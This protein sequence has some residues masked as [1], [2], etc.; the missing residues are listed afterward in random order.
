MGTVSNRGTKDRPLWYCRYV[1]ADGKRK[2]RPTKQSTKAL[3]RRFVAAM[4]ARV[5]SRVGRKPGRAA[6]RETL[7]G[8]A[9]SLRQ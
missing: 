7:T 9:R 3:A 2:Q 1:D 8:T 6:D 5:A 4:E